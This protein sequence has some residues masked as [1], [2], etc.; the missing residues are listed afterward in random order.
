MTYTELNKKYKKLEEEYK[1]ISNSMELLTA[2]KL[3]DYTVSKE[4][5]NARR[6]TFLQLQTTRSML[7]FQISDVLEEMRKA[8]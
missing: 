2:E 4:V 5:L 7:L 8:V 6:T 1:E 3:D